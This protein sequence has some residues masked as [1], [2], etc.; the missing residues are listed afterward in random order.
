MLLDSDHLIVDQYKLKS[1]VVVSNQTEQDFRILHI[2]INNAT[3]LATHSLELLKMI[4][5]GPGKLIVN[6]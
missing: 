6:N 4:K 2:R 5:S 3:E 1:K